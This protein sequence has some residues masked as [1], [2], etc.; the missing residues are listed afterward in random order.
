[1]NDITIRAYNTDNGWYMDT[2]ERLK[3]RATFKKYGLRAKMYYLYCTIFYQ[4]V[5]VEVKD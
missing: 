3:T 5:I 2:D 4:K 1:M